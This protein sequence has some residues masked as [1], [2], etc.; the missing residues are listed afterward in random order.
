MARPS[1][2]ERNKE[3]IQKYQLGWGYIRL[4]HHYG[5]HF[6][7]IKEIIERWLPVYGKRQKINS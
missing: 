5:L 2:D 1:K 4:G 7:T 3:I 6:T